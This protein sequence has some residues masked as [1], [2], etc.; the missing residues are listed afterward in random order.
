VKK[1]AKNSVETAVQKYDDMRKAAKRA[2]DEYH[3][4][5]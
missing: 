2:L 5:Y 1:E 3:R 4:K